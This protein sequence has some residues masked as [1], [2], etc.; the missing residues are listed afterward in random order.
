MKLNRAVQR[1]GRAGAQTLKGAHESRLCSDNINVTHSF[2]DK[3]TD[4]DASAIL[5]K[6]QYRSKILKIYI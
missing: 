3:S 6:K 2:L 5:T 4:A 1:G